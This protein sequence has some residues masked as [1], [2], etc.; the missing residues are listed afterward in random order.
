MDAIRELVISL[1]AVDSIWSVVLRGGVWLVISM[2]IIISVDSSRVE[3]STTKLKK[4]LGFLLFFMVLSG[5]L[6]YMLF[7]YSVTPAAQAAG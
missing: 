5:G 2:V 4:N 7:G 6:I 1:F 3:E